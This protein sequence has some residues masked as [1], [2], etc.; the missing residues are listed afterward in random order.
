MSIAALAWWER[1]IAAVPPDD[2]TAGARLLL[3]VLANYANEAGEAY[4][5]RPT[6]ARICGC[7]IDSV[8]TYLRK[9]EAG[10]FIAR[11]RRT[12]TNGASAPAINVLL[13]GIRE[14]E[15]ARS[16]GW[17]NPQDIVGGPN[18]SALPEG[19]GEGRMDRLGG[20]NSSA[21]T[22][23]NQEY[24]T[25]TPLTPQAGQA[26]PA[27]GDQPLGVE[28]AAGA[29]PR[30]DPDED[31]ARAFLEA[32]PH[33]T[34]ADVPSSVQRQW[35]G[36]TAEERKAAKASAGIWYSRLKASGRRHIPSSVAYLRDRAWQALDVVK[37][38][39]RDGTAVPAEVFVWEGSDAWRSWLQHQR[40]SSFPTTRHDGRIGWWFPSLYPPRAGPQ[41]AE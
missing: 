23:L 13:I 36:L 10:G 3:S 39:Q 34:L 11:I 18:G 5:A 40:K 30:R 1:T 19:A 29:R 21:P 6:M 12:K 17:G 33:K 8:D 22:T 32:W 14:R 7:S 37:A 31:G 24:L 38:G 2:L 28:P 25:F 15:H 4:P 20:P 41:A 26:E 27:A 16:L 35:A 9:L